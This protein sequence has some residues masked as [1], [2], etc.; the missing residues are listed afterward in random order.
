VHV[1]DI[2]YTGEDLQ[3]ILNRYGEGVRVR[4]VF[5][6]EDLGAIQVWGPDQQEPVT[7]L[8]ASQEFA[9]GLTTKQ[10]DLIRQVVRERGEATEDGDAL[11]RAKLE[12]T[13]FV[14]SLM[15]SRKQSHRR[16]S[17]SIRGMSSSRPAREV[18]VAAS[19]DPPVPPAVSA[20]PVT[21]LPLTRYRKFSVKR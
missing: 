8:A 14:Q 6:P 18:A 2:R 5:D 19:Y 11:M 13:N 3:G 21:E 9:R 10:N 12:L 17:A 4:V 16:R 15:V 7:V 1:N 20:R